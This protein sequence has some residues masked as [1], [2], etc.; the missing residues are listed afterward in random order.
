MLTDELFSDFRA[1]NTCI[2]LLK[3]ETTDDQKKKQLENNSK[4]NKI[5][6]T[7]TLKKS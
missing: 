4:R 6:F 7:A 2:R 1:I 3:P 5:H